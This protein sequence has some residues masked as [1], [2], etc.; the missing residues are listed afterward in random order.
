MVV[1]RVGEEEAPL[2]CSFRF[3]FF[4]FRVSCFMFRCFSW[5]VFFHVLFNN[6]LIFLIL[7]ALKNAGLLGDSAGLPYTIVW[8]LFVCTLCI[9]I[10]VGNSIRMQV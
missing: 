2:T 10:S 8:L 6:T 1:G 7:K 5:Y 9:R 3:S 4:V